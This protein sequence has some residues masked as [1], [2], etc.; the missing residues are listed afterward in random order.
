[1]PRLPPTTSRTSFGVADCSDSRLGAAGGAMS[2]RDRLYLRP[3][4]LC[5]AS[6]NVPRLKGLRSSASTGTSARLSRLPPFG[7]EDDDLQILQLGV[8]PD[9]PKHPPAILV[10]ELRVDDQ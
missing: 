3:M 10:R 4:T 5:T 7:H 9:L 8:A 1:M 2:R 6:S